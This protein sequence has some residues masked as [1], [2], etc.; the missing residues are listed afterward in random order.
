MM[1]IYFFFQP[2]TIKQQKFVDVPLLDLRNFTLYKL[3]TKG[4]KTIM[5]GDK[6]LRFKDRYTV[7]AI[8]FTD[9]SKMFVSNMKA[10]Y[11]IYKNNIVD[12][13]SHVTYVREDGLSFKSNSMLYNTKTTIAKTKDSYIAYKDKSTIIGKGLEYNSKLQTLNSNKVTITYKLKE[14]E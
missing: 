2:L 12:L 6:A 4:L 9:N 8:D 11:G 3:D 7:D 5:A 10:D 1:M 13:K 14:E